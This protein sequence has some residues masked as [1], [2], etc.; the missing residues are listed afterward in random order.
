MVG[1][2]GNVCHRLVSQGT[3]LS[4]DLWQEVY[5]EVFLDQHL[6]GRGVRTEQEKRQCW[7]G[8]C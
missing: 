8:L 2:G 1:K 6:E 5:R 7:E 3:G 4:Q